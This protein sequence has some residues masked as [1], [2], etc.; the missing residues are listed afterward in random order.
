MRSPTS[1]ARS[2]PLLL[3][4]L[5]AQGQNPWASL[6]ALPTYRSQVPDECAGWNPAWSNVSLTLLGGAPYNAPQNVR[7]APS[8][9]R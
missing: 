4:P 8:R 3:W 7:A 5:D 1:D 2:A 9:Q 6:C